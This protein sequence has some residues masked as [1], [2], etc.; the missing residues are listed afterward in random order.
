MSYSSVRIARLQ[1]QLT[2]V[3]SILTEL[4]A[5]ELTA[6][7]QNVESYSIDSGEGAQR[8]TRRKLAEIKDSIEYYEA[9]EASIV[10]DLYNNGVVSITL[11]RKLPCRT[12]FGI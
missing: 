1:K 11:R 3:Q 4:Y 5:T 6:A 12:V 2:H 10:N 8:I 9:R 7:K